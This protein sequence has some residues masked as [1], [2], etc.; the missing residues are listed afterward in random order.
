MWLL[1]LMRVLR[2]IWSV[3][4]ILRMRKTWRR[5]LTTFWRFM[6][7]WFWWVRFFLWFWYSLYAFWWRNIFWWRVSFFSIFSVVFCVFL[8]LCNRLCFRMLWS[9]WRGGRWMGWSIVRLILI[10]G[11]MMIFICCR[12][13][14]WRWRL[15]FLVGLCFRLLWLLFWLLGGRR[16]CL[17]VCLFK[18]NLG[19]YILNILKKITVGNS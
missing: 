17:K 9:I 11:W 6:G 5:K 10:L 3:W 16:V 1:L 12:C 7:F 2:R 13:F 15:R 18:G 19:F 4:L 14:R 8:C